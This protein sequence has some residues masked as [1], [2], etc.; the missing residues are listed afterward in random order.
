MTSILN[1][2]AANTA[3]M[4]L[5]NTVKN[6][7]DIQNQVS[8]GLRVSTAAD[9]ASYFSIASVLRTDSSA[10]SSVS[11]TLNQGNSSLSVA[12]TAI[13]QI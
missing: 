6:L 11:D 9:N 1:N 7:Q 8:T 12:A 3:L 10:L 5:Q 2:V 4:N 13:A